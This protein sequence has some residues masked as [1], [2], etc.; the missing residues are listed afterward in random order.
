MIKTENYMFIPKATQNQRVN[1]FV[2]NIE[3]GFLDIKEAKL[4][5][6]AITSKSFTVMDTSEQTVFLHI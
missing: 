2:S 3:S 1:I 5:T 6:E 4:P